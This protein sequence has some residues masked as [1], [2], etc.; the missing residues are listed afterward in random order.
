LPDG[1]CLDAWDSEAVAALPPTAAIAIIGTGLSMADSVLSLCA[2]GHR[3]PLQLISR[4][5]LLPLPHA[6]G[7][8][9]EIDVPALLAL[10]LRL[11]MRSLREQTRLAAAQGIPWQ[12]V[13]ECLRP[14]G[15]ALWQSLSVADQRRFL[16]H[17]LRYW[18]VHRHRVASQVAVQLQ[19]L[20]DS[21]Q[22][23]LQR[24]RL[25]G[26]SAAGEG[27]QIDACSTAGGV[28]LQVQ[29]LLNATG[30]EL[31]VQ[32]MRNPLL[33]QLLACGHALAGAHGIGIDS[34]AQGCLLDADGQPDP[35]IR[36][37]GS[38]RI[39]RLWESLAI[40]ELRDQARDA[41]TALLAARKH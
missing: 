30:V 24:A 13:M 2:N 10:P 39:G 17:V 25:Q 19:A 15:Q 22:L 4:H 32:A 29:H 37:I 33:L 20:R 41:A 16:R 9:A 11:R 27:V 8:A 18:D 34:D 31:R 26:V 23:Q 38:L 28:Q 1:C 3:G 12:S 40:P 6:A 7:T 14:H 36:V 35:R 5:G 21:G